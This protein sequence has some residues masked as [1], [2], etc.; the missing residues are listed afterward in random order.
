MQKK[1]LTI[2]ELTLS[3]NSY[4]LKFICLA[5]THGAFHRGWSK[6]AKINALQKNA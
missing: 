5:Q 3:T 4:V 2:D 1:L 6:N